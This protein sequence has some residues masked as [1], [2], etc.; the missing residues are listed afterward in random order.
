MYDGSMGYIRYAIKRGSASLEKY[1]IN[2]LC[3]LYDSSRSIERDHYHFLT[4]KIFPL[5][6]R[7]YQKLSQV[8]E[9]SFTEV[10]E[11]SIYE[12][13]FSA[14]S[15][16][17]MRIIDQDGDIF[18][19]LKD[20]KSDI[21]HVL[22]LAPTKLKDIE[23]FD[24]DGNFFLFKDGGII[25]VDEK[26]TKNII[27]YISTYGP[28]RPIVRKWYPDIRNDDTSIFLQDLIH[29]LGPPPALLFG[30]GNVAGEKLF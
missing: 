26:Y 17:A 15:V 13:L 11:N 24:Q 16:Y 8:T 30:G 1:A 29:N 21:Y 7:A 5:S 27:G 28:W 12:P 19:V 14:D 4:K 9:Y 10:T 2:D 23:Y 6:F 25:K 3:I 18:N 22:P 20:D